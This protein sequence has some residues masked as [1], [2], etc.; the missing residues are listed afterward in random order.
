MTGSGL[1]FGKVNGLAPPAADFHIRM[2][3]RPF[4]QFRLRA[5]QALHRADITEDKAAFTAIIR[6]IGQTGDKKKLN[7]FGSV[8]VCL[9]AL[10]TP[11][12]RLKSV[13]LS[14]IALFRPF[15]NAPLHRIQALIG[16]SGP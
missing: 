16:V 3:H 10:R 8:P 13:K 5:H 1:L 4:R 9:T 7:H 15:R 14:L 6:R 2:G 11:E 12:H